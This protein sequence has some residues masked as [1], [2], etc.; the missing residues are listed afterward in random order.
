MYRTS[1]DIIEVVGRWQHLLELQNADDVSSIIDDHFKVGVSHAHEHQHRVDSMTTSFGLFLWR[2]DLSITI[3][4]RYLTRKFGYPG[5]G[6]ALAD[7]CRRR[8]GTPIGLDAIRDATYIYG[9]INDLERMAS[10]RRKLWAGCSEDV[11]VSD[12]VAEANHVLGILRRRF[13]LNTQWQF[14]SLLPPGASAVVSVK[15]R[16]SL[17]AVDIFERSAAI[18]E[19]VVVQLLQHRHPFLL[20]WWRDWRNAP[21]RYKDVGGLAELDTVFMG[22]KRLCV[23]ALSGPCDPALDLSTD[24]PIEWAFP[25]WRWAAG[26]GTFRH[27]LDREGDPV[28]LPPGF[29]AV[30][31]YGALARATL[32]GPHG[33]FADATARGQGERATDPR[34]SYLAFVL[35]RFTNEF[36]RRLR[37]ES[38]EPVDR[39]DIRIDSLV[40]LFDDFCKVSRTEV[41]GVPLSVDQTGELLSSILSEF[42]QQ[43]TAKHAVLGDSLDFEGFFQRI[44][45]IAQRLTEDFNYDDVLKNT[46]QML[47][48]L[49]LIDPG[50]LR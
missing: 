33:I 11:P 18:W 26:L 38:D 41:D 15:G 7:H 17:G 29:A 6:V 3:D 49:G 48:L 20:Q 47:L 24:I 9:V 43:E 35:R 31:V 46:F 10:F 32:N 25:Q 42:A 5:R 28:P 1:S 8:I 2:I 50:W 40:T 16:Q 34:R 22:Y 39:A 30:D 13:D 12:F 21:L 45:Q 37:R 19:R 14:T 23:S 4:V 27:T 44:S 36:D